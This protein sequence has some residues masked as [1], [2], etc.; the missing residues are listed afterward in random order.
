MGGEFADGVHIELDS[1]LVYK[2]FKSISEGEAKASMDLGN[3]RHHPATEYLASCQ[4]K[5]RSTTALRALPRT[6]ELVFGLF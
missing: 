1:R 3:T 5:N 6:A 4:T 2:G